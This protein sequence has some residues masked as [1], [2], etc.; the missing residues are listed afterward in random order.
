MALDDLQ[1]VQGLAAWLDQVIFQGRAHFDLINR[2]CL[3]AFSANNHSVYLSLA[4]RRMTGTTPVSLKQNKLGNSS[5]RL[6]PMTPIQQVS[7]ILHEALPRSNGRPLSPLRLRLAYSTTTS[8]KKKIGHTVDATNGCMMLLITKFGCLS[9]FQRTYINT[10]FLFGVD[11]SPIRLDTSERR[12]PT[13][14]MDLCLLIAVEQAAYE[15]LHEALSQ[16]GPIQPIYGRD[17]FDIFQQTA[18]FQNSVKFLVA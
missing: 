6:L 14:A 12:S 16:Y 13:G 15:E 17:N 5:W 2:Y 7:H 1:G 4:C 3:A 10:D 18:E 8:W 9:R 11:Q